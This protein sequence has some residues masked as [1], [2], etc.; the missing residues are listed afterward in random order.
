[1]VTFTKLVLKSRIRCESDLLQSFGVW[2]ALC[3]RHKASLT[4]NI[5]QL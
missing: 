1:M 5:D 2:K 3:Q 4:E